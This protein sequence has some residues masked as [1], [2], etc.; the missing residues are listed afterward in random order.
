MSS[1][2]PHPFI[3]FLVVFFIPAPFDPFVRYDFKASLPTSFAT[4]KITPLPI[5][6]AIG[7]TDLPI[8]LI[9]SKKLPPLEAAFLGL[10]LFFLCSSG[11]PKPLI[12]NGTA[13]SAAV[14]TTDPNVSQKLPATSFLGLPRLRLI[15]SPELAK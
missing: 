13:I 15:F 9:V 4:G 12:I 3:S 11:H 6:A 2:I 8:D 1:I 10:P 14:L 7:A 5:S